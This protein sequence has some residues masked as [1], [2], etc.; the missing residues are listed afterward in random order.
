MKAVIS[1][2]G[3]RTIIRRLIAIICAMSIVSVGGITFARQPIGPAVQ[4]TQRIPS[5]QLDSLVAPIALYP[6][7]LLSQTLVASTY[8]LEIMQLQQWLDRNKNL[9]DEAQTDAVSKQPWDPSI[10]AMAALPDVAKRLAD[11]IEW[12]TDLGN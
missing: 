10:Q 5:E 11:D 3:S 6:D 9:K 7:P 4:E 2:S 1:R 12:T 8:P